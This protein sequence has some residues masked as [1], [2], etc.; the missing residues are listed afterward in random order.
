MQLD[1]NWRSISHEDIIKIVRTIQPREVHRKLLYEARQY[2]LMVDENHQLVEFQDENNKLLS[3]AIPVS[4]WEETFQ[5][6]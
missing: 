2:H 4:A 5:R 1:A 6:N 3:V